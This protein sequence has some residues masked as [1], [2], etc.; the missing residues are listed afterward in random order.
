MPDQLPRTLAR[1]PLLWPADSIEQLPRK[2]SYPKGAFLGEGW[3]YNETRRAETDR[4]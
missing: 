4:R 2:S 3:E 1:A